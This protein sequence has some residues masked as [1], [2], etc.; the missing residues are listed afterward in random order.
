MM[1]SYGGLILVLGK[2]SIPFLKG[3]W[4]LIFPSFM[5][6]MAPIVRKNGLPSIIGQ[7]GLQSISR[8]I[9]S[10]G[11]QFLFA[12]IRTSL[13]LPKGFLIVESAKCKLREHS[14]ISVRPST[15][16]KDFRIVETLAPKSHK[17]KHS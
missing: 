17:A 3:N 6:I 15:S 9:K 8:T 10:M 14:S 7:D 4:N 13:I 2:C 5:S 1:D 11:T 16:H 12:R